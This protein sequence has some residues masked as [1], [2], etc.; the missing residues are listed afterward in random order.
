MPEI[1]QSL[2]GLPPVIQQAMQV[3]AQMAPPRPADPAQLLQAETQRKALADQARAQ[4]DQEKIGLERERLAREAAL[5]QIKMRERQ[6]EVDAKI[7]MNREDNMTAKELAVFEAEQGIKTA[8]STG[9]GIN[10]QP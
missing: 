2:Q 5:D 4:I 6:M 7:S 9:R 8:Y 10:P 1:Q 3:M